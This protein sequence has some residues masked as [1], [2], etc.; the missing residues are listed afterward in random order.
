M[1]SLNKDSKAPPSAKRKCNTPARQR[2]PPPPFHTAP[3]KQK[4]KNGQCNNGIFFWLAELRECAWARERERER[5][6]AGHGRREQADRK[7]KGHR[8]EWERAMRNSPS[9]VS[10]NQMKNVKKIDLKWIAVCV[11]VCLCVCCER[12]LSPKES[13]RGKKKKVNS[14]RDSCMGRAGKRKRDSWMAS[15]RGQMRKILGNYGQFKA[16]HDEEEASTGQ[17]K[18]S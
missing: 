16:E 12:K 14:E 9:C 11:C 17:D 6:T 1:V 15:R 3:H 5:A 2:P 8:G 10:E 4:K 18:A 13:R 7:R